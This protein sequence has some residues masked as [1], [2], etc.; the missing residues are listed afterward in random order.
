[1]VVANV[2][3]TA[4]ESKTPKRCS[5][6]AANRQQTG[7]KPAANRLHDRETDRETDR[8][9]TANRHVA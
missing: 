6:P 4:G 5:K 7:S 3:L 9:P 8:K 2:G 1:M